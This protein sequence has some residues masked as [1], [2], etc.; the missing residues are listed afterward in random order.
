MSICSCKFIISVVRLL[1]SLSCY[2]VHICFQ[3]Y[4]KIFKHC[5]CCYEDFFVK[6]PYFSMFLW[7]FVKFDHSKYRGCYIPLKPEFYVDFDF[8]VP[9]SLLINAPKAFKLVEYWIFGLLLLENGL[10]ERIWY[11]L[12]EIDSKTVHK[13]KEGGW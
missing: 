2:F 13:E 11:M 9:K 4:L 12:D 6:I 7:K 5:C 3:G 1:F 8:P 10:I